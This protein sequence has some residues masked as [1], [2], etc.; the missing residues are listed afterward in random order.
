MKKVIFS[1]ALVSMLFSCSQDNQELTQDDQNLISTSESFAD[2]K[3][4]RPVAA[5]DLTSQ[6]IYTGVITADE[7]R[8][9]GKLFVN[10]GNDGTYRALAET[11]NKESLE[12][13]SNSSN[14]AELTSYVFTGE[15]GSFT[16]DVSD[17]ENPVISNVLI[18]NTAGNALVVKNTSNRGIAAV[19]G[20]FDRSLSPAGVAGIT[21]TWDFMF[22][23]TTDFITQVIVTTSNNVMSTDLAINFENG[24]GCYANQKPFFFED[25]AMNQYELMSIGQ[26]WTLPNGLRILYDFGFS[27]QIQDANGIPYTSGLFFPKSTNNIYFNPPLD[28][29]ATCRSINGANGLYAVINQAGTQYVSNGI[30]RLDTSELVVMGPPPPAGVRTTNNDLGAPVN[31]VFTGN[32]PN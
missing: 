19:L 28:P 21:G 14:A 2:V 32:M 22:D 1:L 31:A 26:D 25:P 7:T 3:S 5:N 29:A 16:L 9:H 11:T 20:T 10:V 12:F 24:Q 18:D 27:K 30:I 13:T 6:G 17:F 23:T 15:R 4:M 8:I